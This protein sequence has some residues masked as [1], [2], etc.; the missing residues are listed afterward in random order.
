[1]CTRL[2]Q[3]AWKALSY[4]KSPEPALGVQRGC[5]D[6]EGCRLGTW[7]SSGLPAMSCMA[8]FPCSS[9]APWASVF[10]VHLALSVPWHHL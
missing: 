5:E 8:R 6:C 10:T 1:M 2:S 3:P 4:G 9:E 7:G